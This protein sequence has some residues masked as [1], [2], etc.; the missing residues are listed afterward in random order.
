MQ[1]FDASNKIKNRIVL[2]PRQQV[3]MDKNTG[4]VALSEVNPENI[5]SWT[6]GIYSFE[7]MPLEQITDR[8]EKKYGVT[9][10]ISD[11]KSRKEK[12]TGKFSAQQPIEEIIEIINF[13][14]QFEYYFRNDTIVLQRK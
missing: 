11:E 13:K 9:I 2:N 10:I 1:T 6:T 4:Y 14:G 7:D 5:L 3:F 8:L 12:Y